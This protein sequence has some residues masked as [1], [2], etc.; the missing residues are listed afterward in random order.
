M[1]LLSLK[2]LLAHTPY[3]RLFFQ[4]KNN[5]PDAF[6]D[7]G[8]LQKAMEQVIS[9]CNIHKGISP[10]SLNITACYTRLT[11]IPHKNTCEA[12]NQ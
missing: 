2:V 1:H 7:R 8:G 12:V 9:E 6:M 11:D 10:H 3:P 5:Q 4:G